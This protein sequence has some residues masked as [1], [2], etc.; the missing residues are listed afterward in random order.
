M[1]EL[2]KTAKSV[3]NVPVVQV[4]RLIESIRYERMLRRVEKE[5]E[6]LLL[7]YDS[8]LLHP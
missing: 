6:E 4:T 8:P 2:I 3:V 1:K 7:G 5:N